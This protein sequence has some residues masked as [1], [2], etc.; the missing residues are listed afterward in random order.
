M[1][2]YTQC[3][4]CHH[5]VTP[6]LGHSQSRNTILSIWTIW[7]TPYF[8]RYLCL[9]P[10]VEATILTLF[11]MFLQNDNVS[12]TVQRKRRQKWHS[13]TKCGVEDDHY[14]QSHHLLNCIWETS[15]AK[16]HMFWKR[17]AVIIM[18]VIW[19]EDGCIILTTAPKH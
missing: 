7:F 8:C 18:I 1:L 15:A 3:H 16:V 17:L 4:F 2:C 14:H 9:T 19:K 11:A 6:H 10:L 12:R 13:F 5:F